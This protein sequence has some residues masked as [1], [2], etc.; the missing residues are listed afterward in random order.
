MG[1]SFAPQ[2]SRVKGISDRRRMPRLGKIR[3]GIKKK[4]LKTGNEYPVEVDYFVCPPE[5]QKVF[6]DKPKEIEIMFPINDPSV[7][8]PQALT[9]YGK[10]K[11]VKCKG[12]NECAMEK[13]EETG[14]WKERECPCEKYK[15]GCDLRG[16]LLFLI[17]SHPHLARIQS[18]GYAGA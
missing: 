15:K 2:F 17:C 4:S 12:N 10:S 7:V 5:V 1:N 16:H 9:Y 11:G 18:S 3:L 14:T 6:G 8:F 13:N